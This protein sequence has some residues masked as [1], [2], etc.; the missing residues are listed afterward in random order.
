[1]DTNRDVTQTFPRLSNS[2]RYYSFHIGRSRLV[3]SLFNF[4]PV[5]QLLYALFVNF[6]VIDLSSSVRAIFRREFRAWALEFALLSNAN[7]SRL[8][9][10]MWR[11]TNVFFLSMFRY[12]FSWRGHLYDPLK[13][14]NDFT[15]LCIASLLLEISQ[16][17]RVCTCQADFSL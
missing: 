13:K 14:D 15:V 16:S 2:K 11:P 4:A 5:D 1:M 12:G 3:S 8:L 10:T 7:S 17:Q 9:R 6:L